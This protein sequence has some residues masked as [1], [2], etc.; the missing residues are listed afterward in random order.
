MEQRGEVEVGWQPERGEPEG[1]H[2]QLGEVLGIGPAA[3]QVRRDD[4]LGVLLEQRGRHRLSH[5]TVVRRLQAGL[6][7]DPLDVDLRPGQLTQRGK[8]VVLEP[9]E[10]A[11][12]DLGGRVTWHHVHLVARLQHRRVRGVPD[13]R[14]EHPGGAAELLDERLGVLRGRLG[15][16]Q[17]P[18]CPEQHLHGG[19]ELHRPRVSADPGHRL[20]ERG[21]SVVG[22]PHG[23]V[24]GIA[25]GGQAHPRHPL[26]GSLDQVE[27]ATTHGGGEPSDLADGIRA[28]LEPLTTV[29]H[30][31]ARSLVPTGL[32]VGGEAEHQG[33]VREYAGTGARSYGREQHR[34]EVLHVDGAATPHL[35]VV[36]LPAEGVQLPVVRVGRYDVEV[37]VHQHGVAVRPAPPGKDIGASG[38]GFP[39]LGL[40]PDLV[41]ERGDV[42]GGLAFARAGLV[43]EVRGVDADEV[44]ADLGDLTRRVVAGCRLLAGLAHDPIVHQ[45]HGGRRVTGGSAP[46]P[47]S[48]STEAR[49]S[50]PARSASSRRA[51]A[52]R[53]PGGS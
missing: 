30:E 32:L 51:G 6:L 46:P 17:L 3:H 2:A 1:T 41:E 8:E 37:T 31:L 47:A 19:R 36:D 50:A 35:T 42:L 9:G 20:R 25:G 43:T 33:P 10:E 22:M 23:P 4:R 45:H 7:A 53:R 44:A 24:T 14:T 15:P 12:I 34:V 28:V 13:H 29:L 26:L 49:P 21:D 40:D 39:Q 38:L 5:L 18:H 27:P 48:S 11:P 16:G 52:P